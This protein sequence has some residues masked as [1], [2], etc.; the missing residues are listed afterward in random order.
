M[1][2]SPHFTG[3]P[4]SRLDLIYD[5]FNSILVGE[6]LQLLEVFGW[7]SDESSLPLDRLSNYGTNGRGVD[8]GLKHVLLDVVYTCIS[9]AWI[10]DVERT[11]IAVRVGSEVDAWDEWPISNFVWIPLTS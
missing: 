9:A 6:L 2:D 7:G 11:P 1:F 3:T 4:E 10:L 8:L 5:H